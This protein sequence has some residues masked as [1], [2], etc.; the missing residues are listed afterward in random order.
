MKIKLLF[1]ILLFAPLIA[2]SQ[3]EPRK[4]LNGLVISDFLLVENITVRNK[5]SNISAVTDEVGNFT[6]YARSSDTL[7]FSGLAFR[8]AQLVLKREHFEE[9]GL[10]V[11][12]D[13]D[14][15]VLDEVIVTPLTGNL[16]AD[17]KK[18]KIKDY[19]G[20]DSSGLLDPNDIR[21]YQFKDPNTAVPQTESNLTGIDFKRLYRLFVKKKGKKATEEA[22]TS[23]V[24]FST[25]A[26]QRFTHYFFTETL[27]IPHDQIGLFLAFCEKDPVSRLLLQ[28]EKEFELI[29]FLVSKSNEYLEMKN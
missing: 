15:N 4:V 13:V 7:F 12:L 5:T 10:V 6:I 22:G 9:N 28:P 18:V 20:Y 25:A 16:A 1:A 23:S 21:N 3:N 27:K 8:D 26:K 19:S 24:S 29:E 14:V 17:A 2:I 11:R